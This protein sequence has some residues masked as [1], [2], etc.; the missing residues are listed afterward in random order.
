VDAV[1]SGDFNRLVQSGLTSVQLLP[2]GSSPAP[3]NGGG[4]PSNGKPAIAGAN[5]ARELLAALPKE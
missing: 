3:V 4:P 2:P 1:T 5:V